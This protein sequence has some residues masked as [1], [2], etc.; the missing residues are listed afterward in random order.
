MDRSLSPLFSTTSRHILSCEF[1]PLSH[2]RL[3]PCSYIEPSP[4]LLLATYRSVCS[5][6]YS[7]AVSAPPP[8]R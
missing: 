1:S 5:P 7:S 6:S 8:R 2:D 4:P 3:S